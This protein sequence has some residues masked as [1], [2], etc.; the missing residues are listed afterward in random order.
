MRP[1][2]ARSWLI[3]LSVLFGLF[4]ADLMASKK[5]AIPDYPLASHPFHVG[6]E[7]HYEINWGFIPAGSGTITIPES[8]NE[9]GVYHIVTTARSNA[10]VDKFY[11]VRNRIET[12]LD[13]NNFR[14]LGYKKIQHEG[15]HNRDVN[16]FF[17]HDKKRVTV[18]KNG[19]YKRT[20]SVPNLTHDPL[21]A[22]YYLRTVQDWE[23]EPVLNI[24]DGKKNFQVRIRVLGKESVET[25]LGFFNTIKIEPMIE[26][27]EIIFDKKKGG[28][29]YIWLTDDENKVPVKMKSELYFGSI[30]ALL[31][32]TELSSYAH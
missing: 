28:K 8:E 29:L 23:S 3:L 14:S 20:I 31:T 24:T 21:S 5:G 4:T 17:D 18:M 12:F 7:L 27:M 10:F 32:K 19:K 9:D 15:R 26:D 22:I 25:P 2:K 11:K 6:E 30:Q 1:I 13:L 16:L